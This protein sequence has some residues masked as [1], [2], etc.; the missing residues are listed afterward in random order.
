MSKYAETMLEE[1][2]SKGK[3]L[4]EDEMKTF[5][6][7]IDQMESEELYCPNCKKSLL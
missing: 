4:N 1:F 5:R 6:D 7:F 3:I 2:A